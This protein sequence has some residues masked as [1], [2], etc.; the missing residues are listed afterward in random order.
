[1]PDYTLSYW[2][3]PFRGH[4]I[5]FALAQAGTTWDEASYDDI[6]EIRT[7]PIADRPYP[8]MAPPWLLDH[9]TQ[10]SLS[11][12]PAIL[13]HLG[14]RHDLSHAPDQE[15][16]LACDAS[17]ILFEITRGHGAQMWTE[18]TWHPFMT[19][20]LPGWMQ[21]HDRIVRE[22]TTP[23]SRHLFHATTPGLADLILAALWHTMVDRLPNLRPVL[24][25]NAPAV[26]SLVDQIAA[27]PAIAALLADWS[28]RRPIYCGGQIE[29]S[30]LNMLAN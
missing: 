28:D 19:D 10:S 6:V 4:F 18:E 13:M 7:M 27:E 2:P 20:R 11:Q 29:A 17:D 16:R 21:L 26:E 23:G 9:T 5:R 22:N 12:M 1:M 24:S 25:E 15:L 8:V 3:I 30:L 14:R